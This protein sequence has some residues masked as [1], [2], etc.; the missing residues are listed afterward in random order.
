MPARFDPQ[1]G[2][3][4]L[5]PYAHRWTFS[6]LPGALQFPP[7]CP[8]CGQ[9]AGQSLSYQKVFRRTDHDSPTRHVVRSVTVPFCGACIARHQAEDQAPTRLQNLLSS[10]S[11]AEMLGAVFPAI[12]AVFVAWLVLKDLAHGRW[13]SA[14]ILLLVGLFFAGIAWFQR[15]HVWENTA[16]L[17]VPPQ[18]SVT[19]AF[20]FSDDLS[21]VF[22]SSR[23]TCTAH[24]ATFAE[25]F[26]ALN[27][28]RVWER[29]SPQAVAERRK[30]NRAMWIFGAVLLLFALWSAFH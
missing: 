13:S 29:S 23:F 7:L 10:F 9:A 16:H 21:D 6:G 11:T 22:E 20:D 4:G 19:K 15:K 8:N 26:A 5:V 2:A 27:S 12:A 18:S 3:S 24:D 1:D 14:G 30:A 25:A 28:E 17:R